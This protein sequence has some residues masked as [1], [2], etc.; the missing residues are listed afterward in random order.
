MRAA[1]LTAM[2]SDAKVV[3][4]LA[5]RIVESNGQVPSL[6]MAAPAAAPA[7]PAASNAPFTPA[8]A[9]TR[10]GAC[11][12]D[13]SLSNPP[14]DA[15]A[16]KQRRHFKQTG[17]DRLPRQRHAQRVNGDARF[18]ARA[19]QRLRAPAAS[20]DPGSNTGS[21][22]NA[23]L[24][25]FSM[26][27]RHRPQP[28]AFFAASSIR[29]VGRI[30]P[31]AGYSSRRF[32]RTFSSSRMAKNQA[33]DRRAD[34]HSTPAASEAASCGEPARAAPATACLLI[35]PVQLQD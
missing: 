17:T 20:M 2:R 26:N 15:F 35:E 27:H 18:H 5:R 6:G 23:S 8:R 4:Y 1:C 12:V 16:S 32:A 14:L 19:P 29:I 33:C 24:A 30:A 31:S 28:G 22:A 11:G 3:N 10:S 34:R 9:L 7:T 13:E 25:A 21:A